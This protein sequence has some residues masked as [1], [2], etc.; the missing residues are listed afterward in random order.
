M[1]IS[2][3]E[4][5]WYVQVLVFVTLAAIIIGLGEYVPFSPVK[6]AR[7]DLA[8]LS[9]DRQALS[10]QVSSLEVYRRRYSEFRA[11]TDAMQ[12]QLDTLQVI[13]PE[14]KDLDEFMRMVQ[15]AAQSAGVEIRRMAAGPV[16][17]KDYH[18]EMTFDVEVDGPYFGIMDFFAR[19]SRLSRIINVGDLFVGGIPAGQS[20]KIPVRPG[21][22]VAGKLSLTTYFTKPG[23]DATNKTTAAKH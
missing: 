11:E 3:R 15:G 7:N 5:P 21:T 8:Q 23:D 1:A 16:T 10:E 13:V 9:Q 14:D 17:P 2:F 22:S 18:Y 12:K 19:L 4:M 20:T 6:T